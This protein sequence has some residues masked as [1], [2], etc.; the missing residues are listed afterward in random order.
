MTRTIHLVESDWVSGTTQEDERVIG[1]VESAPIGGPVKVRVTQSDREQIVGATIEIS[2][3]KVRKLE[4][5]TLSAA[6]ELQGLIELALM[7]HDRAW[8]EEL[9][10][11]LLTATEQTSANGRQPSSP[12]LSGKPR[13]RLHR[14]AD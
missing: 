9:S 4:D 10:E 5:H 14:I 6:D 7:T 13:N 3:S 2:R 8:F 11:R 1:Y 12:N